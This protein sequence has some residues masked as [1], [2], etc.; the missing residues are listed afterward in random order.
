MKTFFLTLAALALSA[1]LAM[2][3]DVQVHGHW[4]DTNH[5]GVKDTYIQPYHRTAPNYTDRD[6]YGVRP[7]Y[8]PY[9]GRQGT[10]QPT[11]KWDWQSR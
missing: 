9:T 6:N 7:N 11:Q 4:R 1:T 8:N 5:D 3:Q 2:A 10:E